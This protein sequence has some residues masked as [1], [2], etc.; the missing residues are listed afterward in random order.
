MK[1]KELVGPTRCRKSRENVMERVGCDYSLCTYINDTS[2]ICR[3]AAGACRGEFEDGKENEGGWSFEAILVQHSTAQ[4]ARNNRPNGAHPRRWENVTLSRALAAAAAVYLVR[5]RYGT[6]ILAW[7]AWAGRGGPSVA[8]GVAPVGQADGGASPEK[9]L[10]PPPPSHSWLLSAP[11]P[12]RKRTG[13]LL[14]HQRARS[15]DL[16]TKKIQKKKAIDAVDQSSHSITARLLPLGIDHSESSQRAKRT[17]SLRLQ[18][19]IVRG[20]VGN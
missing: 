17:A 6:K 7:L 14:K 20:S 10:P 1:L 5:T 15:L 2:D 8:S 9:E 12:Y 3:A 13:G 4:A 19:T 18:A 11:A 16:G